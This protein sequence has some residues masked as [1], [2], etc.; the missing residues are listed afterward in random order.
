MMGAGW[1]YAQLGCQTPYQ[2]DEGFWDVDGEMEGPQNK[3]ICST[4]VSESS[5]RGTVGQDVLAITNAIR[6]T[7]ERHC[8]ISLVSTAL[9]MVLL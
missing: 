2:V 4:S 8:R 6:V 3:D 9:A 7:I 5:V 1:D